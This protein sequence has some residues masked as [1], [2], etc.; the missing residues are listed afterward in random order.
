MRVQWIRASLL[1]AAIAVVGCSSSGDKSSEDETKVTDLVGIDPLSYKCEHLVSVAQVADALGGKVEQMQAA[2]SPEPGTAEPCNYLRT[3][4][5]G[6]TEPWSFD[7]D[8]RAD[9]LKTADKLF[10]QY[11]VVKTA[12]TDAGPVEQNTVSMVQIGRK[13]MDH[14]GQ[15]LI[16]VDDDTDCYLRVMGP[17]A[18]GRLALGKLLAD[19]LV[20]KNAPMRPRPRK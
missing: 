13:A 7:M 16:V 15:A 12:E 8:C 20:W 1:V 17:A 3:T 4:E 14:H 18:D 9:A 11:S 5:E 10:A 2:F 6:K 19:K